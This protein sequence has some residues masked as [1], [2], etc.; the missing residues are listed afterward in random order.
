MP[1]QLPTPID[2]YFKAENAAD[3]AILA[4][5][6]ANDAVVRDESKVITGLAAITAWKIASKQKYQHRVEPLDVSEQDG[7]TVVTARVAGNFPG[8]PVDLHFVFRLVG[9]KITGLEIR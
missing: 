9:D 7:K 6:F 3:T 1:R 5:C 4:D 8:S 2:T